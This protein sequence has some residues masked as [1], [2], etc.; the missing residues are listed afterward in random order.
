MPEPDN[1]GQPPAPPPSPPQPQPEPSDEEI[2]A[3]LMGLE[4]RDGSE[5]VDETVDNSRRGD[6][7]LE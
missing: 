5:P 6:R 3:G 1:H 4:S 2:I 7:S